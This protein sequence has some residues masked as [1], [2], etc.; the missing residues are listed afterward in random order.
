MSQIANG[1]LD[2][3]E[4]ATLSR[5]AWALGARMRIIFDYGSDLRQIAEALSGLSSE[6]S[7]VGQLAVISA[8]DG[9]LRP[10]ELVKRPRRRVAVDGG[11]VVSI[12]QRLAR[13]TQVIGGSPPRLSPRRRPGR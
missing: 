13:T 12:A 1:D 11:Q 10:S 4:V 3:N 2:V 6:R 5:Y 9:L 7:V 8:H